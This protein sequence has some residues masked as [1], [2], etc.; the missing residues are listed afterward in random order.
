MDLYNF[1]EL[2]GVPAELAEAITKERSGVNEAL[3]NAVVTA[4]SGAPIALGI[5][6]VMVV[7]HKMEGVEVPT[8]NTVRA[9]LNRAVANAA[10]G[11]PSRQSYWTIESHVEGSEGT[12]PTEEA[13]AEEADPLADL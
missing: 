7:L 9:Y 6:Q 1:E 4:V 3:Y 5:K 10:I 2:D 8:E 12:I 11:K 13:P